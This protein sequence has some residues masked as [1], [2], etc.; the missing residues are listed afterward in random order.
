MVDKRL[1]QFLSL[2]AC[3]GYGLFLLEPV[4]NIQFRENRMQPYTQPN[5]ED[6]DYT[7]CNVALPNAIE[8]LVISGSAQG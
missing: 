5:K 1:L 6:F 7:M 3:S 8:A 2:K 4:S